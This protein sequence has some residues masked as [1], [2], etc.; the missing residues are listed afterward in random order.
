MRNLL[1]KIV[2]DIQKQE[3]KLSAEASNFIDGAYRLKVSLK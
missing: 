1:N 2:S 3:Q